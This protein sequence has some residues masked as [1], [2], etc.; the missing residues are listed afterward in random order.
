LDLVAAPQLVASDV[1]FALRAGKSHF[2]HNKKSRLLDSCAKLSSANLT[3]VTYLT[4]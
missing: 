3:H 1:L 2:G 4:M